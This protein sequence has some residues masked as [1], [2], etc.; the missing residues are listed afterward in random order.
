MSTETSTTYPA[1]AAAKQALHDDLT[2][3]VSDEFERE[4][5]RIARDLRSM[6]NRL[7]QVKAPRPGGE[8]PGFGLVAASV[9]SD[10]S[11]MLPNLGLSMLVTVAAQADTAILRSR[12]ARAAEAHDSGT[13]A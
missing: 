3:H 13:G 12:A 1:S 9:I 2:A 11:N 7:D 6:A 8:N 4:V 5:A 10:V